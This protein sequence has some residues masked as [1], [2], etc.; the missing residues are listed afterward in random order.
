[1]FWKMLYLTSDTIVVFFQMHN[2]EVMSFYKLTVL[3]AL[4]LAFTHYIHIAVDY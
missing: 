4:K 3:I 1:M 2:S